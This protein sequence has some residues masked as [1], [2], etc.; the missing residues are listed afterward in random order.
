MTTRRPQRIESCFEVTD[1]LRDHHIA[2][3]SVL[4][5]VLAM[6]MMADKAQQHFP[7]LDTTTM[8]DITLKRLLPIDSE[9]TRINLVFD[10]TPYP[11]E[12]LQVSLSTR[13]VSK[14][15][16]IKRILDHVSMTFGQTET[17]D[18]FHCPV[19]IWHDDGQGEPFE[20]P[21]HRLYEELVPFGPAFQNVLETISLFSDGGKALLEAPSNIYEPSASLGAPLV[22]DAAFHIACAWGQRYRDVVAYPVS[23]ATRKIRRPT[24]AGNRYRA[25]VVARTAP[26][27]DLIFD[28]EIRDLQDR[29]CE[30]ITGLAMQPLPQTAHLRPPRWLRRPEQC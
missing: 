10:M 8:T 18:G 30:S 26:P 3:Q 20:V 16:Q 28:L 6:A 4:P 17:K 19:T 2:G 14:Q 22:L 12:G 23:I 5:A 29:L 27:P 1:W 7:E 9:T 21:A 13:L 25:R 11:A 15:S 24:R